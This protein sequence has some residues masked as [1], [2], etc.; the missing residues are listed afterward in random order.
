[1]ASL[2]RLLLFPLLIAAATAFA[3][4]DAPEAG[5]SATDTTIA[6]D[7]RARHQP[8][9]ATIYSAILPGAGQVYNRKYWKVPIVLGG[10]AASYWFIQDN[11]KQ[12]QR[13]KDAYL[14]VVN[15]RP[16][17]FNG[18]Y[19]GDQLRN[20][21]DTY[22]RWRDMSYVALG[23]VYVLN[24]VDATVDAYFVRFDVNGDLSLRVGPSLDLAARGVPGLG[25]RI[26]L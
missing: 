5:T 21:A 11:N 7:W 16:D 3:Q 19:S 4:G 22:H 2:H 17:E 6:P 1:M 8:A 20:V 25:I 15:G 18:T 12:Y 10:L 23:L 13:Y 9:R 24:I 14:D 26:G